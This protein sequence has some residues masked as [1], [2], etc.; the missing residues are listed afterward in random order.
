MTL[1]RPLPIEVDTITR[2]KSLGCIP[3]ASMSSEKDIREGFEERFNIFVKREDTRV[4][5]RIGPQ[6]GLADTNK[7][8]VVRVVQNGNK[9]L[10]RRTHN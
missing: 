4:E 1:K 3:K 8:N 5:Y 10:D 9:L 7:L 6:K 2:E